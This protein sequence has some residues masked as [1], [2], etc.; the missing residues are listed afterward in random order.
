MGAKE[1]YYVG[2]FG[3]VGPL[4]EEHALDLASCGVISADTYVW[5]EGMSEWLRAA[6]VDAFR[7]KVPMPPPPPAPVPR[8]V[9]PSPYS[10]APRDFAYLIPD[11]PRSPHSRIAAGVLNIFLPG[12]GRMYLGFVGL[13]ILQLVVSIASCGILTVWPFVDGI[14]MLVGAVPED[15]LGRRLES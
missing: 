13:G 11:K 4:P 15:G 2:K 3:Q 14:L 9:T 1:W 5:S 7:S 8:A 6:E 10:M 12:V